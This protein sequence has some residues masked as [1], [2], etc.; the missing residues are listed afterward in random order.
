MIADARHQ[1]DDDRQEQQGNIDDKGDVIGQVIVDAGV[2]L[3]KDGSVLESTFSYRR[4]E[5]ERIDR[6]TVKVKP[7]LHNY[8]FRTQLCPRRTG[9]L[10]VGIG[11]NNGSTVLGA[12]IANREKLTW[13]TR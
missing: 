11:G 7:V 10:L 4:N 3:S 2:N 1:G 6:A 8:N 13:R 5:I 12:T 9:L